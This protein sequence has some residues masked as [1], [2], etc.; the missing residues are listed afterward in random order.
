VAPAEGGRRRLGDLGG[1]GS[2]RAC[3]GV[4]GAPRE[5]SERGGGRRARRGDI[6]FWGAY[7]VEGPRETA[8]REEGD[9]QAALGGVVGLCPRDDLARAVDDGAVVEDECRHHL[10]AGE[11]LHLAAAAGEVEDLRE[12]AEAVGPD[13]L[14]RV[15][16]PKKRLM[17]VATRMAA[18]PWRPEGAVADVELH[19]QLLCHGRGRRR[20][21]R[22]PA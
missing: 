6:N 16:S 19:R 7:G 21:P 10:I 3:D 22:F 12:V 9:E 4:Q 13:D 8:Q 14:R 2:R 15:T 1:P 20:E 17:R 18:R 11:P 5:I